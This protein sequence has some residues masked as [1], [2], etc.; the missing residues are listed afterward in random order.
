[1]TATNGRERPQRRRKG[2]AT[3][4]AALAAGQSYEDAAEAAG[5]SKRTARRRMTEPAFRAEVDA[6]RSD[7]LARAVG[8]MAGLVD[9]AAET[10]RDVMRDP[11]APAGARVSAARA[12]L[13]LGAD[14]RERL[15]LAER[16]QALEVT[17]V[18]KDMY[19]AADD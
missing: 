7:M 10:L 14:L 15:E 12:V 6:L 11:D 17:I 2:D 18:R 1:M 13:Q 16:V 3:L 5:V 9:E 8:R 4:L 19:L